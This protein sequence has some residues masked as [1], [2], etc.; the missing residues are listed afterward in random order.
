MRFFGE[1]TGGFT[2]TVT[3]REVYDFARRWPCS[4]LRE[5]P[6]T[7]AFDH[8]G[9]LVDSDDQQKQPDADGGAIVALSED[10]HAYGERRQAALRKR[11]KV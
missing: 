9:N 5:R 11:A 6:V 7:F 1:A 3:G 10:A 8:G 4:G 2:V